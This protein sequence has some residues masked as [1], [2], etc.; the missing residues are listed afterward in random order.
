MSYFPRHR[1]QKRFYFNGEQ[2]DL[3]LSASSNLSQKMWAHLHCC[4]NYSKEKMPF[5]Q[6]WLEEEWNTNVVNHASTRWKVGYM[7]PLRSSVKWSESQL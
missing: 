3:E 5:A 4:A 6:N 7:V 2:G 1:H